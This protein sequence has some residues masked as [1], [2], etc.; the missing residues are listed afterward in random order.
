MNL[1][2]MELLGDLHIFKKHLNQETG[3]LTVKITRLDNGLSV[4]RKLS[5]IE[6]D[7]SR[8]DPLLVHVRQMV[9]ELE[10]ASQKLH[11]L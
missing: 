8:V 4:L 5:R 3:E 7:T 1:E 11:T 10:T 6:L 9:S 2:M